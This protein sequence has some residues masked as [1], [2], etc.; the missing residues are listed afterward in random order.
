MNWIK[1]HKADIALALVSFVVTIVVV[2]AVLYFTHY[3]YVILKTIYPRFYFMKDLEIGHDIG[4][5]VATTTHL[6]E[7]SSY[8]VWSNDLGCFDTAYASE[9]PYI[10]LAGDSLTWGFS[11]FE[12]MWGTRTQDIVGVRTLKCGVTGGY[13]TKQ[14]FIKASRILARL[15][16]P[17]SLIVVEHF[18][19]ND[20]DED[21]NFPINTVYNGYVMPNLAKGGV[22]EAQAEEKYARFDATCTTE[23]PAHPTVQQIR[24]FLS[25]H[26]VLYNFIKKD[27]RGWL[28]ALFPQSVLEKFDLIAHEKK[29]AVLSNDTG[30]F[31]KHL[32][33][34]LSFKKLAQEKN[35][36]LLF[37]LVPGNNEKLKL[38]LDKENISY[39]DLGPAFEKYGKVK[40]L[41]WKINGH[42]N[43]N[44]QH[45][46]G[47]AISKFIIE[48]DLVSVPDKEGSLITI[49]S[50][51]R[52]E[53]GGPL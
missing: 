27:M 42:W 28:T 39:I 51:M 31:E 37:V 46:A 9:T 3:R 30:D 10:Y 6:F 19:G 45:L 33:N 22:T 13:G 24:C 2:D 16:A 32:Q 52:T 38:F 14:E 23:P 5:N 8:P 43:P 53:F 18:D 1:N 35:S 48:N 34:I 47:F 49:N 25:N 40:P 29:V 7:D 26:S 44:G 50:S 41:R 20:I 12:D 15:P 36:K 21:T 17:P 11:P 4:I